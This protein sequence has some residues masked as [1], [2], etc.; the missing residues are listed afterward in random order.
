MINSDE[1][2]TALIALRDRPMTCR[3]LTAHLHGKF[4]GRQLWSV[5]GLVERL[6]R[7]ALIVRCGQR[8]GRPVYT[9]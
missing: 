4:I 2:F 1:A 5:A 6:E 8:D 7:A 9:A 3:E